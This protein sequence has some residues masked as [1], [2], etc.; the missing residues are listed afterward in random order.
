[1]LT[2][3]KI[4]EKVADQELEL[5]GLEEELKFEKTNIIN[6]SF[7]FLKSCSEIIKEKPDMNTLRWQQKLL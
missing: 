6:F 5:N 1:M 7:V 3:R 4:C 2:P